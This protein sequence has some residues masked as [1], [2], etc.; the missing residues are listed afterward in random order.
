MPGGAIAVP[1][2]PA[3][4]LPPFLPPLPPSLPLFLF[5]PSLPL[6]QSHSPWP[7]TPPPPLPR[8]PSVGCAAKG[9]RPGVGDG[10]EKTNLITHWTSA[11][12][13]DKVNSC[14]LC[15]NRSCGVRQLSAA[16]GAPPA[17]AGV[18]PTSACRTRRAR[19]HRRSD[20]SNTAPAGA[21]GAVAPARAPLPPTHTRHSRQQAGPRLPPQPSGGGASPPLPRC[22]RRPGVARRGGGVECTA[23]HALSR[24]GTVHRARLPPCRRAPAV[25]S[26]AAAPAG[27][28]PAVRGPR[29]ASAPVAHAV[30][31]PSAARGAPPR[32]CGRCARVGGGL[33]LAPPPTPSPAPPHTRRPLSF[34]QHILFTRVHRRTG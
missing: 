28:A 29:S 9:G 31:R 14:L 21:T 30:R 7:R 15:Q 16:R 17:R 19:R 10:V 33:S 12:S 20:G 3:E 13:W 24:G 8:S 6:P 1:A 22:A 18:V 26:S 23:R 11:W 34:L 32:A 25:C 4:A 5:S 27:V 2:R